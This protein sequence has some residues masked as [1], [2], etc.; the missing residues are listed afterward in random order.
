MTASMSRAALV[1]ATCLPFLAGCGGDEATGDR[2]TSTSD[3]VRAGPCGI[4]TADELRHATGLELT[5]QPVETTTTPN[6]EVSCVW[7]SDSPPATVEVW[8]SRRGEDY[9][10]R[11]EAIE[12]THGDV[13]DIVVPE[14]EEAFVADSGSI[15]GL[16]DGDAYAEITFIYDTEEL[17]DRTRQ[18][19]GL[20]AANL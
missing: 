4:L 1:V 16:A 11:R 17:G 12:E 18:I 6:Q 13:V 10:R 5:A 2:A 15:V 8:I 3:V 9:D 14:A 7:R 20:A 19:A